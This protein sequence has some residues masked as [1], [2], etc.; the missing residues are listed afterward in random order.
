MLLENFVFILL[1]FPTP[2]IVLFFIG[3]WA[4][5][6]QSPKP[7][8]SYI[9]LALLTAH[10]LFAFRYNVPDRYVFFLPFYCM[11]AVLIALGA[12]V[13]MNRYK[14][15]VILVCILAFILLPI[16][17]YF[18]AP[19]F[20][21]QF[22]KPLGQRRQRPYRD[23]YI[24]FL[25]PW[26]TGY[27]G[28]EKFANEALDAAEKDAIIYADSTTAH[29]LLYVQQVIGKRKDIR[30]ISDFNKSP[31]SLDLNQDNLKAL[32]TNSQ[33]YVVSPVSGYCPKFILDE[34]D[35]V[36]KGVIYK[37]VTKK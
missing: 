19:S 36:K 16:P 9:F 6:K 11:A 27:R 4:L 13:I 34:Y 32:T 14:G 7:V 25:Q 31:D 33:L 18:F 37:A 17:A 20:A 21:K 2:N 12:D 24:Y 10:F 28:A 29:C 5:R 22:Y 23:E 30:I 3:L 1:N 8:F 26:K 15:N 35:F